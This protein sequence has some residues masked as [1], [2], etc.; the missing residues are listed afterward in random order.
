MINEKVQDEPG[1]DDV[2]LL[3]ACREEEKRSQSQPKVGEPCDRPPPAAGDAAARHVECKGFVC[4]LMSNLPAERHH[5]AS[6]H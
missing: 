1:E 2:G 6:L 3:E 5:M 4:Q